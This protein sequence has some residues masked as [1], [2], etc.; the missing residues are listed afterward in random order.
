MVTYND[1]TLGISSRVISKD[2][3]D[4]GWGKPKF[5]ARTDLEY[6]AAKNTL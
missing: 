1:E 2:R 3:A 4:R 6:K 5:L